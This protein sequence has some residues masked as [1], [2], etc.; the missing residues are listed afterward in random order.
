MAR[1]L[2]SGVNA[3]L[4]VRWS[5]TSVESFGRTFQVAVSQQ[6]D[7]AI[8]GR[9]GEQAAGRMEGES[10]EGRFATDQ[11]VHPERLSQVPD[12]KGAILASGDQGLSVGVEGQGRNRAKVPPLWKPLFPGGRV[13]QLNALIVSSRGQQAGGRWG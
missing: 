13:P 4:V 1:V 7:L 8:A 3:R 2:P 11:D 5:G 12:A 6:L 9:R 10:G